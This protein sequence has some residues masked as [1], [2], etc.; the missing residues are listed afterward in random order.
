MKSLH[1]LIAL[2][3]CCLNCIGQNSYFLETRY[4]NPVDTARIIHQSNPSVMLF[5]HSK[6][7]HRHMCMTQRMLEDLALDSCEIRKEYGLKLYVV[8][9]S[10]SAKDIS[11]FDSHKAT[12]SE[13]LFIADKLDTFYGYKGATPYVILF[14]GNGKVLTFPHGT[15]EELVKFIETNIHSISCPLCRGR[16]YYASD[17]PDFWKDKRHGS[18]CSV[19]YGTGRII[20]YK[21]KKNKHGKKVGRTGH[22]RREKRNPSTV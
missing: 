19:C 3:L 8:Y 2:L 1:I 22:C 9:P 20:K 21:N 16:G 15:Y 14:C 12:N 7:R 17:N 13:I 18:K 6:C 11:D 10:F 4:R 5:V